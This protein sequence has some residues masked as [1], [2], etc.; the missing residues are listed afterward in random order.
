M[1]KEPDYGLLDL[2]K[3]FRRVGKKGETL[4]ED[5]EWIWYERIREEGT[6]VGQHEWDSAGP[7][8]GADTID[9]YFF[10]GLFIADDANE[11]FGPYENLVDA[12]T[13]VDFLIETGATVRIWIDL[14][15][16][17]IELEYDKE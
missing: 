5:E 7:G 11:M 10:R 2:D 15:Y 8:A 3:L 4:N 17:Q 1:A 14:D 12:A 9:I 16:E 6:V 13:A